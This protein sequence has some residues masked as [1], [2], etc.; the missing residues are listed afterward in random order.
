MKTPFHNS[1]VPASGGLILGAA[2]LIGAMAADFAETLVDPANTDQASKFYSA[3]ALHHDRMVV[4]AMLLLASA[5]LIVPGVFGIARSLTTRGRTLGVVSSILGVLGGAGHVAL[6]AFYLVFATIPSGGQP[7]GQAVQLLEHILKSTEVKLLAPLAIAFPLAILLTLVA[8]VRGRI[9]GR[10]MLIPI[11]G[12][13]VLAIAA[14]APD[15]VKTSCALILFTLAAAAILRAAP[16]PA[17]GHAQT[18]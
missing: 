13:P 1:R 10:R 14:P 2:A 3:S 6:A 11:I 17:V 16:R 8:T 15:A 9:I 5:L 18:A 12:A 7:R 4:S